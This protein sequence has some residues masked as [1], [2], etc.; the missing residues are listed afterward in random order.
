MHKAIILIFFAASLALV[1]PHGFLRVPLARTSIFRQPNFGAQQPFWWDDT[2]VWCGNVQQDINFS[3]C[4]RCGDAPGNTNANQGG[5][6]DK[7][8]VTATYNA[9]AVR[10]FLNCQRNWNC[11]VA[12]DICFREFVLK[13]KWMPLTKD[14]S[15]LNC[16]HNKLSLMVVSRDFQSFLQTIK[17]ETEQLASQWPVKLY[18]R[19][20]N[21]QLVSDVTDVLSDGHTELLILQVYIET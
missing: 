19:R 3:S 6:Y 11:Y 1:E 20:F 17:S 10:F 7:G 8:I 4:G 15:T 5:R 14:S 13:S 16:V 12:F 18:G 9:G 2:G 21:S